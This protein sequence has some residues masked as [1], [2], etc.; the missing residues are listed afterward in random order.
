MFYAYALKSIEHDYYY[1]GHCRNLEK[2]LHQHNSGMTASIWPYI[3][4]T[5]IYFEPFETEP[6]AIKREKYYKSAAGRRYL[7]KVLPS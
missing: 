1:K 3:P 7:K 6:E 4:F 2:R 5:L